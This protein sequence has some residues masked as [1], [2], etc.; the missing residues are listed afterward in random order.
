MGTV[1]VTEVHNFTQDDLLSDD[2]MILDCHNVVYEWVGQQ[3]S[4][5]EKEHSLDVGKVFLSLQI[6]PPGYHCRVGDRLG[7]SATCRLCS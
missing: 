3:A 2:I 7:V 6:S 5:E 1:Q 4:S